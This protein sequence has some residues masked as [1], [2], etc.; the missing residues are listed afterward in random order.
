MVFSDVGRAS[1][2]QWFRE[3]TYLATPSETANNDNNVC[4]Y[5]KDTDMEIARVD[6]VAWVAGLRWIQ[7]GSVEAHPTPHG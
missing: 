5:R 6:A 2:I 4:S 3:P 1:F 7:P